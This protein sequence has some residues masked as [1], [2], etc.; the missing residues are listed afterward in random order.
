MRLHYAEISLAILLLVGFGYVFYAA[1]VENLGARLVY[2]VD[3]SVV[4]PDAVPEALDILQT[5]VEQDLSVLHNERVTVRI[6]QVESEATLAE[7]YQM[8]VDV[9][10]VTSTQPVIDSI[11]GAPM[12]EFKLSEQN[13]ANAS[14]LTY[15]FT[16]L[17][18]RSIRSSRIEFSG[19]H[20][21]TTNEP[22]I[23]VSFDDEG[24]ELLARLTTENIG[25]KLAIFLDGTLLS[26]PTILEPITGGSAVISGNFT[27]EE[28]RELN[29]RLNRVML[30]PPIHLVSAE[31]R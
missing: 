24:K 9:Y 19:S 7:S 17:T 5:T 8:I 15:A 10:G 3:V 20:G 4:T 18:E 29:R 31:L 16:G 27:V 13:D 26:E 14:S 12:L 1:R 28:V 25:K 2:E 22:I 11:V 6:E 21:D 30:V 23:V